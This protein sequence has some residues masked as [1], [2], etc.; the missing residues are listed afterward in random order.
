MKRLRLLRRNEHGA[1]AIEF[2][3]AVPVLIT[4][5]WGIFQIGLLLEANAGMRHALGEGARY[6]TLYI[7][8]TSDHRPTNASIK[9]KIS[10]SVF[11]PGV[12]NFSVADPVDGAGFKT[13]SVTYTMPMNFLFFNGPTVSMTRTKKV[14][15]VV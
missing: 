14:Y 8:S 1:A 3:I 15:V 4:F 5:I 6:A 9:S 13:L 7:D 11:R 2:A 10:S 12:G